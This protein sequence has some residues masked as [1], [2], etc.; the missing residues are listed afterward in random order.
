MKFDWSLKNLLIALAVVLVIVGI[1]SHIAEEKEE[2]TLVDYSKFLEEVEK[3]KIEKV[4]LEGNNIKAT[5]T[6]QQTIKT[7]LPHSYVFSSELISKKV[8]VEAKTENVPFWKTLL[9]AWLPLF[10]FIGIFVHLFKGKNIISS[11]VS[12]KNKNKNKVTFED[13]AG[14]DEAKE[15]MVEI[16]EFLKNPMKFKKIGG[17][18][19]KGILL[20][21]LPGTGK[22]L[23]AKA[24]AGE[25]NVPFYSV[26]GSDFVEMYVGVGAARVRKTFAIAK[27]HAPCIIFI[28]EL[29]AVGARRGINV[30]NNEREQTLNQMLVEMDG[31]ETNP[32][33]IVIAATNRADILDPALLRPGRFDRRITVPLPDIRGREQ[34][35]N[36]HIRAIIIAEDVK[37][38]LLAKRTSGLAGADLA[39]LVNEAAI[40]AAS[41]AKEAVTMKDFETAK[42]K[43]MMGSARRSMVMGKEEIKNIAY[44]EAGHVVVAKL[45]PCLDLVHKASIIPRGQSL[46][47]TLLLPEEDRHVL[48]STF[49]LSKISILFGGRLAEEIFLRRITNGAAND[50]KC[51][52]EL[53]RCMVSQW[54]MSHLGPINFTE[55]DGG[56]AKDLSESTKQKIDA[57]ISRIINEQY[58]RARKIIEDNKEKVEQMAAA[59]LEHET[60]ND[61]QINEI[62]LS[63]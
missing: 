10:I 62:M 13:V 36:A 23:L 42:D 26:S 40:I 57:E 20:E 59:L 1:V 16:V 29:D 17:K 8:H 60:I 2:K 49:L 35:L 39:N 38:E 14:C 3:G 27:K 19:P 48:D 34:I 12:Q 15:E 11:D 47:V 56:I 6:D 9:S 33:V 22:T 52:S 41:S 32:G 45:I 55:E 53:A 30:Q 7:Y 24:I 25:A 63:T 28:D 46:G 43:I 5:T 54:G 21:G 44:H 58:S 50:F 4:V 31:F 61:V 18:I 37:T 51:A